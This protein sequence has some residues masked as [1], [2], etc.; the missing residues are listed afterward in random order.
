ASPCSVAI[1]RPVL[2]SEAWITLQERALGITC[3]TSPWH[4]LGPTGAATITAAALGAT[5]LLY[6]SPTIE[7]N[8]FWSGAA[9]VQ[10]ETAACGASMT[11]ADCRTIV[12]MQVVT[13]ACC[14]CTTGSR[15]PTASGWAC[16]AAAS[17]AGAG[18]A[19]RLGSAG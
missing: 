3:T 4:R 8:R 10:L 7:T 14:A 19:F 6:L 15:L 2:T 1:V 17:G 13:L 12:S 9:L 16:G 18:G 5:G 11:A